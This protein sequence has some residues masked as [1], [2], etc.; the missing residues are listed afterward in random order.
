MPHVPPPDK[1]ERE[2]T[3]RE[4]P[5]R[6]RRESC[7]EREERT[8]GAERGRGLLASWR[9]GARRGAEWHWA[10]EGLGRIEGQWDGEGRGAAWRGSGARLT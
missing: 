1:K 4:T 2:L 7:R 3:E 5:V 6:R 10:R 8:E 9:G